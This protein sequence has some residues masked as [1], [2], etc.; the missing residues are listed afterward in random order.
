MI[1]SALV[2]SVDAVLQGGSAATGTQ[3]D[4]NGIGATWNGILSGTGW[5]VKTGVGTLNLGGVNTY[6][7]GTGFNGGTVVMDA[8]SDLGAVG[9]AMSFNGGTLQVVG[10]GVLSPKT[11]GVSV[12]TNGGTINYGTFTNA[13]NGNVTGTGGLTLLGGAGG[14]LQLFGN[15]NAHS[16]ALTVTGGGTVVA[17]LNGIGDTSAVAVNAPTRATRDARG[18]DDSDD[19]G[20]DAGPKEI[21]MRESERERRDTEDRHPDHQLASIAIADRSA[22]DRADSDGEKEKEQVELRFLD[23][24]LEFLDQVKGVVVR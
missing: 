14:I 8:T 4:T 19:D 7:G 18:Q 11:G 20:K 24:D 12:L 13:L 5:I 6:T 9:S 17:A 22:D 3:L 10:S 1:D 23:R 2:T 16:G 15:N 21:G